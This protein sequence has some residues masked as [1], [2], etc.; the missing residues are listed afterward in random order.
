MATEDLNGDGKT[1]E[2]IES[3]QNVDAVTAEDVEQAESEASAAESAVIELERRVTT[4]DFSIAAEDIDQARSKSR[5]ARLLAKATAFK[6]NQHREAERIKA[7]DALRSEIE[8][9]SD[10]VGAELAA[11]LRKAEKALTD[12][13]AKKYA[14]DARVGDWHRRAGNLEV[15]RIV[16][17]VMPPKKHARLG[18][19]ERMVI[20]GIRRLEVA[21]LSVSHVVDV[22]I[23]RAESA[24][25]G[26]NPDEVADLAKVYAEVTKMDTHTVEP[27]AGARFYIG[28]NGALHTF[29]GEPSEHMRGSLTE[30]TRKQAENYQV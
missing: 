26:V 27:P 24:A 28:E 21:P 5:F 25:R 14:R 9:H 4:G 10:T 18:I 16:G 3:A 6:A 23:K 12:F 17:P 11:A 29:D 13:Y 19:N 15:G 30:I 22:M 7:C 20:A 2:D 8:A 1:V